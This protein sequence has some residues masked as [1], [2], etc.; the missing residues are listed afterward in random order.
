MQSEKSFSVIITS[1]I[2]FHST[3]VRALCTDEKF[4]SYS[5]V[6][7]E[8]TSKKIVIAEKDLKFLLYRQDIELT[9][10]NQLKTSFNKQVLKKI[11]AFIKYVRCSADYMS[12]CNLPE[13][14]VISIRKRSVVLIFIQNL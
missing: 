1:L 8:I 11:H 12:S 3:K 10:I 13:K 7:L 2:G 9:V 4:C 6:L 5:M 14:Y